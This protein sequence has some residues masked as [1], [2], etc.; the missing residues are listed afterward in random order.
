MSS[1]PL[2][3]AGSS[4]AARTHPAG[5]GRRTAISLPS[6][7]WSY[8][9]IES[10]GF[11]TGRRG[12]FFQEALQF[13]EAARDSARN[14]ARGQVERLADRAVALVVGEEAVE[15]LATVVGHRRHRLVNRER[16]VE[17]RERLVE[18]AGLHVLRRHLPAV[19]ADPV[20]ARPPRQLCEPGPER[21]VVPQPLEVG[22]DAGED[23]LEH[24]FGVVLAEAEPL[25]ADGI[26]VARE[27]LDGVVPGRRVPGAASAHELGIRFGQGGHHYEH[28]KRGGLAPSP[29]LCDSFVGPRTT[30][31]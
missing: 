4:C 6:V 9:L 13:L 11:W 31:T 18:V 25:R 2:L 5:T 24:V 3:A 21:V 23:V 10:P 14:R 29:L 16:L 27:A 20:D 28:K 22:V 7:S 12:C 30:R 26:D 15:D 1:I 17:L 8:V 19:Q